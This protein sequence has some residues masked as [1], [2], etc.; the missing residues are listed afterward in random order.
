MNGLKI[1]LTGQYFYPDDVL[2]FLEGNIFNIHF[3]PL[4]FGSDICI[5]FFLIAF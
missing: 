5:V 3:V 1:K 2:A 4:I